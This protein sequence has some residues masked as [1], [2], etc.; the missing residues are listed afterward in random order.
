M[1]SGGGAFLNEAAL[2]DAPPTLAGHQRGGLLLEEFRELAAL[3]LPADESVHVDFVPG[4]LGKF[5]APNRHHVNFGLY[6]YS[7]F[8]AR[9]RPHA[10]FV[11]TIIVHSPA[12]D[13]PRADPVP[14]LLRSS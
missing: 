7:W 13:S 8:L 4:F 3:R 14:A 9:N 10:D 11:L 6:N 2:P 12:P 1:I 5:L